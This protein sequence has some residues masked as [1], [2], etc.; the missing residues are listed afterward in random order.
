MPISDIYTG[1]LN[2]YNSTLTT[3]NPVMSLLASSTLGTLYLK[4][5]YVVGVR[6]DI[7]STTAAA[8]NN[9]LFQLARNTAGVSTASNLASG[10]S[11]DFSA[12]ASLGQVATTWTSAPPGL[13]TVLWEQELPQTTGSSWEEFPPAGYEWQVPA[14]ANQT[15]NAGL[16][17]FVTQSIVTPTTINVDLIWS[18]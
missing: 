2:Q 7:V 16:H 10:G 13:G 14:I 3:V 11:H 18:E 15:A 9:I 12:P 4:R 8:G 1:R 6:V 5:L 17:M